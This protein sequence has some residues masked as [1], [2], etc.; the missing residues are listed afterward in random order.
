[1]AKTYGEALYSLA[2]E[3]QLDQRILEELEMTAAL[4]RE[5]PEYVHLL[6]LPS[7]PKQERCGMLDES[8]RDR[9]HPYLLNFLKILV[10]RGAPAELDGCREAYRQH[11]NED[12]GILEVT[13]VTAVPLEAGLLQRLHQKLEEKTGKTVLLSTKVEPDVLGGVR[14]EME[15]RRLDGTVRS[16]LDAIQASLRQLVL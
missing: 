2:R 7:L 16:R 12:H 13:A 15:G 1:M 9:V 4:F 10:E 8:F 6:S 11:Y 5:N 14:L 3:E